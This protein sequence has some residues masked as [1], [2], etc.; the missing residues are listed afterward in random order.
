MSIAESFGRSGFAAFISSPAGR[1]LRI[2][3]GLA[4]IVAGI[5]RH[6][7]S[8]GIVL[9]VVGAIPFL[10]GALDLCVIS[11]LLGGPIL[12]SAIR[13]MKSNP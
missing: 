11:A 6:G 13:R 9:I 12:S 3:V 4:L 7:G 5:A 1:I 10:A 2:V 8:G